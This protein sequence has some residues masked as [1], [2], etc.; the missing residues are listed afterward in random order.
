MYPYSYE[1]LMSRGSVNIGWRKADDSFEVMAVY[2]KVFEDAFHDPQF[3]N[4]NSAPLEVLFN[5]CRDGRHKEQGFGPVEPIPSPYGFVFVDEVE[6]KIFDW[7]GYVTLATVMPFDL[8][9][10]KTAPLDVQLRRRGALL[11]FIVGVQHLVRG[12]IWVD[13]DFP[14]PFTLDMYDPFATSPRR[15]G[16]WLLS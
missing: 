8:V 7:N 16:P 5:G 6:R 14:K 9:Y 2:K 3:M 15:G 10:E 11:P 1:V 13:I 12:G 4:G